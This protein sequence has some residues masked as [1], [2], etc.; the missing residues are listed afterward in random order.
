MQQLSSISSASH[1]PS[2][3]LFTRDTRD[4]KGHMRL[5]RRPS[6]VSIKVNVAKFQLRLAGILRHLIQSCTSPSTGWQA[7]SL[8]THTH[9]HL[10]TY[11]RSHLNGQGKA[12]VQWKEFPTF[13]L[14]ALSLSFHWTHSSPPLPYC[15][16]HTILSKWL[17]KRS[18]GLGPLFLP[19]SFLPS[20]NSVTLEALARHPSGPRF[21]SVANV[22]R[23]GLYNWKSPFAYGRVGEPLIPG[24]N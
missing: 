9:T 4:R 13:L 10:P 11:L 12:P 1:L 18:T 22:A 21:W 20:C 19:A 17:S 5:P 16:A 24:M 3:N 14:K 7:L 23:A 2:E 15:L 8:N 6:P